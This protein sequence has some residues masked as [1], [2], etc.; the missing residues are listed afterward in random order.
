M[1]EDIKCLKDSEQ[2]QEIIN[3]VKFRDTLGDD[4]IEEQV[5]VDKVEVD[6]DGYYTT[7][8]NPYFTR[9][10]KPEFKSKLI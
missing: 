10:F 1:L 6:K 4:I 9:Y 3:L 8:T 7:N 2:Y 5:E